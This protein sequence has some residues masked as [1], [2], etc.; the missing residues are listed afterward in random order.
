MSMMPGGAAPKPFWVIVGAVALLTLIIAMIQRGNKKQRPILWT[1][2][3]VVVVM[4]LFPPWLGEEGLWV[5]KS[6][7]PGHHDP[8]YV[9]APVSMGYAF[10]LLPPRRTSTLT[11]EPLWIN[12]SRLFIQLGVVAV[13]TG[14]LT[15]ALRT[16]R[17]KPPPAEHTGEAGM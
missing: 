11:K 8:Q 1:A 2:F 16:R 17:I 13:I 10:I 15:F 7:E 6:N 9:C 14:G 12:W 4:A 5:D 3:V